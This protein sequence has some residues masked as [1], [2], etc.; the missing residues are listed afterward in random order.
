MATKVGLLGAVTNSNSRLKPSL[1]VVAK[2]VAFDL[3]TGIHRQTWAA[4][5]SGRLRVSLRKACYFL[6]FFCNDYYYWFHS[7]CSS[8]RGLCI[9]YGNLRRRRPSY[10][11]NS[12]A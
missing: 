8:L 1:A 5:Y 6:G 9:Y 2:G 4:C 11:E 3:A 7:P 10:K 12:C